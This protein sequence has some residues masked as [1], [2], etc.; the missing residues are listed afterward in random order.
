MGEEEEMGEHVVLVT[1][2]M[3]VTE[4]VVGMVVMAEMGAPEEK[5][6]KAAKEGLVD[7]M[8]IMDEMVK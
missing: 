3:E 4:D 7:V 2:G 6:V 5:E 1:E 8:G